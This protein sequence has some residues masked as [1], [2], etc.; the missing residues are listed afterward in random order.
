MG[1]IAAA[2]INSEP[3]NVSANLR[4]TLKIL[5]FLEKKQVGF[6]LFPELNLSGYITSEKEIRE[7]LKQLIPEAGIVWLILSLV[8]SKKF[9]NL[10]WPGST[11]SNGMKF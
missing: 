5:S 6:A 1:K 4:E 3:G 9:I 11:A 10:K 7:V 8:V 2:Y